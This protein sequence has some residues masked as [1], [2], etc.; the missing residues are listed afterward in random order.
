MFDDDHLVISARAEGETI[1]ARVDTG[2][3][4]TDLYQ[5][6]ADKFATLLKMNGKADTRELHGVGPTETFQSVTL[7]KLGIQVGGV[8]TVLSPAHVVL[9]SIGA[10][11]CVGNFGM[12]LFSQIPAMQWTSISAQWNY[13][14]FSQIRQP[15]K[16]RCA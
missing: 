14:S 1:D 8:D 4:G 5:P 12:D 2:A 10:E 16:P 3:V 13:D 15:V 11:C 9:K 7:P 6:F